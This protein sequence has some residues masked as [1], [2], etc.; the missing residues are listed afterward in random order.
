MPARPACWESVEAAS[1]ALA[2]GGHR[3]RTCGIAE[4][5]EFLAALPRI[6]GSSGHRPDVVFNLFEGFAGLGQGEALVAGW[7][8]ALGL[9][10]IAAPTRPAAGA[11]PR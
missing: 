4:L 3:A 1:A 5:A 7:I 8:E 6:A 11:G 9:P 10:L 2:A